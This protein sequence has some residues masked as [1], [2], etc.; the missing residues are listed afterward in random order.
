MCGLVAM[1]SKHQMG[2]NMKDADIFQQ[3]L[4]ADAVRGWDAT[5]VMG[6]DMLG[7]VDIK[8]KA[9]A[10]GPFVITKEYED[11][12]K[13]IV[14]K[15]GM[16]VGHNR[17][18]TSG[19]KRNEDAH[20]FWDK[21]EKVCLVHNGMIANHKEFCT[22]ST[23]DSASIATA[24]GQAENIESV[25]GKI[26]G[27][28]ALIWYDTEKRELNFIRNT[29]RPLFIVETQSSY[30]LASEQSMAFWVCHRNGI[31]VT[32]MTECVPMKLYTITSDD[33]KVVEG[34][35]VEPPKKIIPQV[36]G[37]PEAYMGHG[38]TSEINA[39][40][41][42]VGIKAPIQ[43]FMSTNDFKDPES[44]QK[45]YQRNAEINVH[46]EN[47]TEPPNGGQFYRVLCSIIN[48]DVPWLKIVA[49]I[50]QDHWEDFDVTSIMHARVSMVNVEDGVASMYIYG[51]T[52]IDSIV[53]A[54]GVYFTDQ[55]WYDDIFPNNC[56]SCNSTVRW[57][58][59]HTATM[60]IEEGI[61]ESLTCKKCGEKHA[62]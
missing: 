20:P 59:L 32:T 18:A 2:F 36:I 5:G 41:E 24:L 51:V 11:F 48:V 25:I 62:V 52:P 19:E 43:M 53:S 38:R 28:F 16:V 9:C 60:W 30:L 39:D 42:G 15:Y 7:N 45:V 46:I 57:R 54:N 56:D 55:M 17:K 6:V 49:N 35:T 22:N 27:A 1:I 47:Y 23:V 34:V 21:E 26:E 14:S 61:V 10:A 3:L 12:S 8:K 40:L 4:Y 37:I 13:K 33:R 29:Q 31:K 50:H 58:D 44:I